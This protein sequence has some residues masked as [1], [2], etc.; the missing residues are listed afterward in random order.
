MLDVDL[1]KSVV[2]I[3]QVAFSDCSI[4]NL[5]IP[6]SVKKIGLYAF[7]DISNIYYS[8]TIEDWCKIEFEGQCSKYGCNLYCKYKL[9]K[10]PIISQNITKVNAYT[11]AHID[12]IEQITMGKNVFEISNSAF[13]FCS[14]LKEVLFSNN[15]K[16]IEASAFEYCYR[17][18]DVYI[19]NSVT[20]IGAGAFENC[21]ALSNIKL[22][23]NITEIS[24]DLFFKCKKLNNVVIPN[25]ITK[26][27]N[28]A[29]NGC[30]SLSNIVLPK[31]VMSVGKF[32]FGE[33]TTLDRVTVL[34]SECKFDEGVFVGS[35]NVTLYGYA[36]STT[37]TYAKEYDI[38]FVEIPM[39]K[40]SSASVTLQDDL[41]LN[42]KAPKSA[43]DSVLAEE[44]VSAVYATFNVN[45]VETKVDAP[46]VSGE[47]YS[48]TCPD[49]A[50]N[51]MNDVVNAKLYATIDGA[52][53]CIDTASYSV[54]EYCYAMLDETDDAELKTLLVDMLNYGADSQVYTSYETDKLANSS[55]TDEQ[56]SFGTAEEP[57]LNSIL[58]TEYEAI[59]NPSAEWLGAG[60]RLDE[61]ISMRFKL[62]ADD[63]TNLSVKVASESGE[64]T[65]PSAE[66]VPAKGGYYVYFNGF[67]A[68]QLSEAVYV[69]VYDGDT[70][71]SNTLRYSIETYAAMAQGTDNE[72]LKS[73]TNSMMKY[74]N[75]AYAYIH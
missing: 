63:I 43:V 51:M 49:I 39:I 8:G 28:N 60:L 65:I 44:N 64:W 35:E 61:N 15:I 19:P 48:F 21:W 23:D 74:G 5:T 58:D 66:F 18:N 36:N 50:P 17:L 1:G 38:P 55:L 12:S 40:F 16:T 3:G 56:K 4:K 20:N 75:S 46:A 25:G 53:V 72:A 14:N 59:D 62:S 54:A 71:V 29:F 68:G 24:Q 32:A 6:S 10:N 13:R 27:G 69:T 67:N 34:N 47:S 22:S 7:G 70:A 57:A 2:S 37:E 30:T 52:D 31:N 11:F 26:I 9:V 33:C 41:S 45:G 42:F 73:L